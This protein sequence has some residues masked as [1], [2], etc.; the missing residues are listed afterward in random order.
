MNDLPSVPLECAAECYVDDTKMFKCFSVRDYDLAM[1]FVNED[2]IRICN[3]CFQNL[4]LLNPGKT[5]LMV[6]GC[7]QLVS[8]LPE[9]FHISLLGKEVFPSET[10]KDLGVIFDP[11]LDFNEHTIKVTCSCMSILGQINRVKHV[12]DKELLISIIYT[13]AFTKLYYCSSVWST[14]SERNLKKLQSVQNFV[15]RIIGGL[16]KYDHVTPILKE[17]NWIPVKKQL[18]YRD[19]VF[20]FKC[21]KGM[22]PSYL[23]SQFTTR[24][25]ISGRITRQ[26]DHLNILLFTSATSQ[27]SFQYRIVK[28]WNDLP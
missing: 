4:L 23:S 1:S 28:L 27:K 8:K 6:Y 21:M 26:S 3:W 24:G 16:Q 10:V 18:F 7:R 9:N 17:L 14:T 19:A 25:T 20:V 13:L 5:H 11:Y 15:S 12:F 2:L 22:A